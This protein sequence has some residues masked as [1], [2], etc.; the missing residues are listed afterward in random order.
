MVATRDSKPELLVIV[1]ETASGKSALAMDI[2]THASGEIIAADSWTVYKEFDIGTAKPSPAEQKL[3]KHHL[4]DVVEAPE[5]FNAPKFKQL[6][7]A[8]IAD[9]QS[10]GKLPIMVGGTG[11]YIDSVLF[12]YGFLP[13]GSDGERERLNSME[14]GGLIEEARVKGISLDNVDTRNKRRIIRAIESG[15]Q[16]P[17]KQLEKE[18]TLIIGVRLPGEL[19][20]QRLEARTDTMLKAGLEEE[21][22]KLSKMYGW[23]AE[24][25]KG[26]G[27]REWREYFAGEQTLEQTKQRIISA[28]LGL[29]KR[30]RTWFKRNK[31]INWF[32][33]SA[34]AYAAILQVLNT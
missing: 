21:V 7:E 4:V 27:Y 18:N 29:A 13:T 5:G 23:E 17:S 14:I 34:E 12:D 25:M 30:Q 33:S 22:G 20:R 16:Q 1:G 24:P 9:I 15:G 10:R 8:A 26:I 2:A 3:V 19:L 31:K 6:A 32:D 28:S 11:L